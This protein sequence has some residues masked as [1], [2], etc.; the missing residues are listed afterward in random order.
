MVRTSGEVR[1]RRT[2]LRFGDDRFT[3]D[4]AAHLADISRP[5]VLPAHWHCE[6][7]CVLADEVAIGGDFTVFTREGSTL[8]AMLV[9]TSGKGQE[10]AT[11]AVMLAG[12]ISGL[13]FELPTDNVLPAVNRHVQRLGEDENFATAVFIELDLETGSFQL[14]N[15]GHP[16]AAHFAAGSGQWQQYGPTG[17]ALGFFDT[18][19]W[20]MHEGQLRPD[21]A[22]LVVTD[23]VVEVPGTD[24]DL[25]VDRLLGEAERLV[26]TG[27]AEG[28]QT[29]LDRRRQVGDD[30]Q[31]LLLTRTRVAA[32]PATAPV[33][34]QPY[35]ELPLSHLAPEAQ[36][37]PGR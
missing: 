11:R 21:D 27:W 19:Y 3:L 24:I 4:L 5:P 1:R 26:L 28:A 32:A 23:G 12:A 36:G 20:G 35:D 30:A 2:G 16:P 6:V 15:A 17:P 9:D 33:P 25:G 29:L 14:G 31:V 7:A 10:A 13:L 37:T 18:A 8:R 34:V 22:L